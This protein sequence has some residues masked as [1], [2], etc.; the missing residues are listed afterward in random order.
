MRA[1]DGGERRGDLLRAAEQKQAGER[2]S[3]RQHEPDGRRLRHREFRFAANIGKVVSDKQLIAT[4]RVFPKVGVLPVGQ[5]EHD[6]IAVEMHPAIAGGKEKIVEREV[7]SAANANRR[8]L[9]AR[10]GTGIG[11][12][13]IDR[14]KPGDA[15]SYAHDLVAGNDERRVE[16]ERIERPIRICVSR[17]RK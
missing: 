8:R 3:A 16:P 17:R 12:Q 9:A 6:A 11:D 13:R 4:R 1:S 7:R 10:I 14:S 2:Q 15:S 5:L